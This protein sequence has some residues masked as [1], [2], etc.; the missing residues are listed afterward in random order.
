MYYMYK[1]RRLHKVSPSFAVDHEE[2][3]N[4]RLLTMPAERDLTLKT[5][6]CSQIGLTSEQ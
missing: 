5:Q 3:V 2:S 1:S 6:V 4:F